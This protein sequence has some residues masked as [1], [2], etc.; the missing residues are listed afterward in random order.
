MWI[1]VVVILCWILFGCAAHQKPFHKVVTVTV[2]VHMVS[3]REQFDYLPY[4][5]KNKGVVGYA[6]NN[7]KIY[8]ICRKE[9]EKIVCPW[10]VTGHELMH[11]LGWQDQEVGDPDKWRE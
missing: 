6:S 10:E 4:T 9:K 7:G 2:E 11:I 3:D 1:G 8:I 5:F